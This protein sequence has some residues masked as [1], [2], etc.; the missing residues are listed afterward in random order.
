MSILAA[1]PT[2][3][4]EAGQW[5]HPDHANCMQAS[6]VLNLEIRTLVYPILFCMILA[7]DW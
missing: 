2:P 5:L 6:L 7:M 3:T 1:P 4:G